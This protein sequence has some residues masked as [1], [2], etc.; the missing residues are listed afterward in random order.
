[1]RQVLYLSHPQVHIDPD[2]PVPEW[3]LNGIGHARVAALAASGALHAVGAVFSSEET[4][5][6]ET[7]TPLAHALDLPVTQLPNSHE[8]DRSATGYLAPDSF[9]R[10]A[11]AFFAHPETSIHGWE[12]ARDAQTR[13]R[14]AVDQA[15]RLTPA[16]TLLIVGHGAVGTLL[17]CALSGKPISRQHDQTGGGGNVFAFHPPDG[18]PDGPW[19]PLET[20]MA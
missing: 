3:G 9:E 12:T 11:D 17:W 4:K 15:L 18:P 10:T 20:L 16:E 5:A 19:R 14:H 13:I 6:I 7:A 1:M 2:T 8:N